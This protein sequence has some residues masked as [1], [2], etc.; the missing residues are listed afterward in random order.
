MIFLSLTR[1]ESKQARDYTPCVIHEQ[2]EAQGNT[3]LVSVNSWS[4]PT[5]L[6]M[7]QECAYLPSP[8]GRVGLLSQWELQVF[9]RSPKAAGILPA[10][11][12]SHCASH[13]G[14]I[15]VYWFLITENFNL[16]AAMNSH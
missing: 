12:A 3:R 1:R 16:R 7:C 15:P 13:W 11:P 14:Y 5:P 4:P 6:W 8:F 2:T 9:L 10:T